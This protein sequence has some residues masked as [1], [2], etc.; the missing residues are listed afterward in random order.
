NEAVAL[1]EARTEATSRALDDATLTTTFA[2]RAA[3]RGTDPWAPVVL[4]IDALPTAHERER[5]QALAEPGGRGLGVLTIGDWPDAPWNLHITEGQIDAPRLG[6]H[7]IEAV[8][9]VQGIEPEVAKATI[10]LF[11][12]TLEDSTD[13]LLGDSVNEREPDSLEPALT[14][15]EPEI[16]V[17]LLG[18][19]HVEGATR[20][21]T[22]LETELV[23]FLAT[24]E[25]P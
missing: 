9:D 4:I 1:V 13:L 19:V 17:H 11:E 24:R 3:N 5:L 16:T 10:Q 22:D 14:D 18:A 2:A 6:L 7:G 21:L 15:V 23:A 12:Q 8:L 25:R 20:P